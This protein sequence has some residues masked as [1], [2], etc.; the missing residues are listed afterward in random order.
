MAEA[1]E[2]A[3]GAGWTA[4]EVARSVGKLAGRDARGAVE[5]LLAGR[6]TVLDPRVATLVLA[7]LEAL[8]R[9]PAG[10]VP[11]GAEAAVD[12]AVLERVRALLA[13]AESTTFEPEADALTAKAHELM[14]RYA[15]DAAAVGD[16]RGQS[17]GP[18]VSLRIG[19]DEPYERAKARLVFVL[20]R[21]CRCKA[22][23]MSQFG[24][25]VVF[26]H[27]DDLKAVEL[28]HTSLLVQATSAMLAAGGD[29]PGGH[30]R[31][32]GFR[33]AFLYSYATRV[34]ERLAE[35]GAAVVADA[36]RAHG[37][38]LLPVLASR[39]DAVERAVD[40]AFPRLERTRASSSDAQ[41]WRA[42][43]EAASKADLGGRRIDGSIG[44]LRAG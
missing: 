11:V 29:Q 43:R 15:I 36:R 26:G 18:V 16:Q 24:L 39:L 17:G 9:P 20:T 3:L 37:D 31:S 41:G 4:A 6:T 40:D 13:K 38:A 34:G 30:E 32:R 35:S 7:A 33:N 28:L 19:L 8:G 27:A 44:Q 25:M 14:A 42:G 23:W 21:S 22:V 2:A 1:I 10:A 12:R 5:S